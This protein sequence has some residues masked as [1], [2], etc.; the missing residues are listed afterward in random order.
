MIAGLLAIAPVGSASGT[1]LHRARTEH[2][3]EHRI[4][5]RTEHRTGHGRR[6]QY[7]IASYYG[8][9]FRGRRMA[10][11]TI[12]KPDSNAAASKTL[13]LGTVAKVTNLKNGRTTTVHVEDRGPFV[14]GRVLDVTPKTARK[15]G[16]TRAGVAPVAVK[17]LASPTA[18]RTMAQDPG[19][20]ASAI[21]AGA[22]P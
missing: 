2:A 9:R 22:A 7:G 10:N 6:T 21:A 15:L 19:R 18:V 4:E 12:F 11:G 3:T 20:K 1:I 17:P 16:M 13:P 14:P 5:H 8:R